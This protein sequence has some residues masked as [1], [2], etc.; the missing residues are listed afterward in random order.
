MSVSFDLTTGKR[1]F[2]RDLRDTTKLDAL[3]NGVLPP[4][5][6]SIAATATL[7]SAQ[8]LGRAIWVTVA[9]QTLTLPSASVL[10]GNASAP[11]GGL[12]N[13]QLVP[14][15]IYGNFAGNIIIANSGDS[16]F[17]RLAA[18]ANI[19]GNTART[20]FIFVADANPAVTPA[21]RLIY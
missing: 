21:C 12:A 11:G 6:S 4:V 3:V 7:T 5:G 17:T 18:D 9:A 20:A 14:L 8:L 15:V 1:N 16:T 13:G 10:I 2:D 19:V